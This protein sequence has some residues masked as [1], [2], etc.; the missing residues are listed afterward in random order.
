ERK[1]PRLP[2]LRQPGRLRSSLRQAGSLI[3]SVSFGRRSVRTLL[4]ELLDRLKELTAVAVLRQV[5]A[6]TLFQPP[7]RARHEVSRLRHALTE[8]VGRLTRLQTTSQKDVRGHG[9][10]KPGFLFVAIKGFVDTSL[11][12]AVAAKLF[13][14][15]HDLL[16][17]GHQ[18]VF[19]LHPPDDARSHHAED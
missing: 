12:V 19:V 11:I 7:L 8:T 16:G 9:T 17:P 2:R 6:T 14:F 15:G 5:N 1:R 3:V 10:A 18:R 13:A 4:T